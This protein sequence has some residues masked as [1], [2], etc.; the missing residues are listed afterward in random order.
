[1]I[2]HPF[3]DK[4][5]FVKWSELRTEHIQP[6][7]DKALLGAQRNLDEI[8]RIPHEKTSFEN[9]FMG[10]ERA[11]EELDEAWGKVSHLTSVC[12]SE[13][14]R[15][16]Y[17][18]LL[19]KVSEFYARIPLN[20]KLWAALSAFGEKPEA[21]AL[22]GVHK[23]FFDETLADFRQS[24]ADL[25]DEK[26][27]RL[28][29]I[30][31]E[32]AQITQKFSENVLDSTNAWELMLQGSSRLSGLPDSAREA[33][34]QSALSKGHGS[35]EDPYY[36]FTLQ[37]P[38]ME[39]VMTYA[40]DEALR[41]EVWV[42]SIG[43]GAKEPYANA[44]LISKILT[45]RQ[46]KAELLGKDNFADQVLERRM[47]KNG[48]EALGFVDG[49]HTRVKVAFDREC[50][51]LEAFK[52]EVIGE[53]G[54]PLEPWEVGYWAEKFRK[55]RY[56]FDEEELRPYFPMDK[57]ISGLFDIAQKVFSISIRENQE[58]VEGWHSE[59]KVYE[60]EDVS[61]GTYLGAFYTDWYPRESK[62]GG[63]WMNS[64]RTGGPTEGGICEPH[65]GLMCGN[66]TAPIGG[67]PALLTHREVETVFHEFG[68][69]I[70]HLLGEVE[71]KSLNGTNVAWDFVELPS[72]IMENWTWDRESLNLFARHH[73][74]G[75][76]IP[77]EL[78]KKMVAARNFCSAMGTMRQ[79]SLGKVDLEMHL[80][81]DRYKGSGA[82]ESIRELLADYRMPTKTP[83]PSIVC[84][85]GHL[86]A[87]P[88]GYAAGYYSYKWAEVLDADAFTRFEKEGVFNA[89]VG[90]E[91]R[92]KILSK[93]NS[94]DPMILFKRF[95]GRGP[96]L[97]A[98]LVRSGLSG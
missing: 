89:S 75:E 26:K 92:E 3:L 54:A 19:P 62:R 52:A 40:E 56:D 51:A 7:I 72:Q 14:L 17:N 13:A 12:D 23:R 90:A 57:V 86:F 2:N 16:V 91:F 34:R 44:D 85:F 30:V 65:L 9:V 63:A 27:R 29:R 58:E 77:D 69:L 35:E 45:L 39:P 84:R 70:H 67:K 28:E 36:R 18:E 41:K 95:M 43:V 1:M 96:D 76:I 87:D 78:F 83:S 49:L 98:L 59:V 74:T 88:V 37:Y 8:Y 68:H 61:S 24:G 94:E 48:K 15:K 93:G 38:S 20:E 4:S 81:P 25:S 21:K 32:L 79:L 97:N 60:I 50:E 55:K 5:F 53:E 10:L 11:T 42:A 71:I 6:D 33:A 22:A 64:I 80:H 46:E 66:M 31:A 73:E 82:E 47:A